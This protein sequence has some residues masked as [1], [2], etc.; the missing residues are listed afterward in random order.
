MTKVG[1]YAIGTSTPL[2]SNKSPVPLQDGL[3]FFP[4][5]Y[6]HRHRLTLRL[7]YLLFGRSD[8]GFPRSAR[9]TRTGEVLS[10]RR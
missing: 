9:L 2:E 3:R 10:V 7:S 4:P 8:P 1:L 6:P 5:P